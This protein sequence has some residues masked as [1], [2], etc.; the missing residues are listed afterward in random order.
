MPLPEDQQGFEDR[1]DAGRRLAAKLHKYAH[2]QDVLVLALPRGGVPVGYEVA[3]ALSAPLDVFLVR[4]LGVPGHEE[5]AMGAIASD[6]IRVLNE[7][8][9]RALR[10]DPEQIE[11]VTA[12]EERVLRERERD[13]RGDRPRPKIKGRIVILVDDGLATG[14]SMRAAIQA[15]REQRPKRLVVAVPVAPPDACEQIAAEADEFVCALTPPVFYGVGMWYEDFSQVRDEDVQELLQRTMR[16]ARF[17]PDDPEPDDPDETSQPDDKFGLYT[18]GG[19]TMLNCQDIMKTDIK[20][21][22]PLTTIEDA[23]VTMRDEGIGFL[24]VCDDSGRVLGTITDRDIVIR[25]VADRK[26]L[27]GPVQEVMTRE[28]VACRST[29]ELRYAE[30]LMSQAQVSRI[31]CIDETGKLEGVISLSDIAQVEDGAR[32][33]GTLRN[34]SQREA[35][36]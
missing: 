9:L 22:S 17:A 3:E 11:A 35:R 21:V 34:V 2:R 32:A 33:A 26:P 10:I 16:G 14:A 8:V 18:N 4:K 7:D 30:E 23:A 24:P 19:S 15:I 29:D 12:R 31:M 13:Y 1:R 27:S 20:C 25:V 36:V 5:L 28:I 6:G